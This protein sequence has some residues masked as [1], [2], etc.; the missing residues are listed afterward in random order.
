MRIDIN[1][2]AK[3]MADKKMRIK[4]IEDASGMHSSVI[5]AAVRGR[6]KPRVQTLGA[7]A[8]ALDVNVTDIIIQEEKPKKE[9]PVPK[10]T[11]KRHR[12][13]KEPRTRRT[14]VLLQPSLYNAL[15]DQADIEDGSVNDII[16]RALE[17][18]IKEVKKQKKKCH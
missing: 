18:Y 8:N 12:R 11:T 2:I 10:A 3:I 7:I 16:H 14:H 6:T 17:K 9:L 1:K 15:A 5:A 4:D 13:A